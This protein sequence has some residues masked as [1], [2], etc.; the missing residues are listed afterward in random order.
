ML[1]EVFTAVRS[2]SFRPHSSTCAISGHH[3]IENNF[4]DIELEEIVYK[5]MY[6]SLFFP[7]KIFWLSLEK[8]RRE[9]LKYLFEKQ[10]L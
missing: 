5:S 8:Y 3:K 2:Y 6:I 7:L 10:F 9:A 4:K 1:Q